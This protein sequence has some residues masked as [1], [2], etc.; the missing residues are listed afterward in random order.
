MSK[1]INFKKQQIRKSVW[2][3]FLIA[4]GMFGFGFA[5]VPLYSVI[6]EVTG[7]NGKIQGVATVNNDDSIDKSRTV[8]LQLVANINANLP[9]DFYPLQKVIKVHPGEQA[10]FAYYAKNKSFHTM[11]VQAVPSVAPGLAAQYIRKTECFCF[12][13]QTFKAGESQEMPV[14][15]HLDKELPKNISTLTLSYTLFDAEKFTNRPT[16]E[17]GQIR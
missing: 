6:C 5:L 2:L 9:W 15:F 13:R 1:P 14:L 3:L 7:L 16:K 10:H 11:T 17:A 8:T 12:T 4:L